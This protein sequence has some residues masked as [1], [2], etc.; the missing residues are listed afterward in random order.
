MGRQQSLQVLEYNLDC[1][2]EISS[3]QGTSVEELLPQRRKQNP[4]KSVQFAARKPEGRK[5]HFGEYNVKKECA[6]RNV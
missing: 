2:H 4:P 1:L 3:V 5:I 6:W